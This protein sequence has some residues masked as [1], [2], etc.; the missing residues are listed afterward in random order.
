MPPKSLLVKIGDVLFKY[1]NL[2]FPLMLVLL[3]AIRPPVELIGG[4]E[5]GEIIKDWIAAAFM[6]LGLGIR[7]AVIGFK[8]IKRG[9]LNKKVYAENLVTDGFFATCRNPLYVGNVIMYIGIFL[10]HGAPLVFAIGMAVFLLVYTAII[11]AEE[12]FL[13][14]KFGN[15]YDA[16]CRDVPRWVPRLSRLPAATHGMKFNLRRVIAKDYTTI[17]N[18]AFALLV[19]EFWEQVNEAGPVHWQGFAMVLAVLVLS[20]VAVKTAKKRGLFGAV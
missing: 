5:Q 3:C 18:G 16:Y 14:A 9:G 1:R 10:M 20:L 19:I 8:Y 6:M 12:Y 15:A 11:A 13:R 2:L 7:A 4:A 17:I